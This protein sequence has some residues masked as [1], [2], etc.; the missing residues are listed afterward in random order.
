MPLLK[1]KR[2]PPVDTPTYDSTKKESKESAKPIWQ[3]EATGKS[4]LTYMEALKSEKE[5]KDRTGNKLSLELQKRVLLHIQFQTLRLDA[6][7]D[8][9]YKYFVNRYIPGELVQC[10]WDD[11]IA[12][13]GK[14]L[15]VTG[16]EGDQYKVQLVDEESL[17]IE[18]M[19]KV[20]PK[21]KIK[22]DR[23]A[24]SK[25]FLKKFIKEH[26]IKDTYI[27][28]PWNIKPETAEKFNIDTTLPEH[29][30][31]ARNTAYAKSRKKRTAMDAALNDT[32]D[33][34]KPS[35][36]DPRKLEQALRYPI[37]DLN[38]PTYRRDPSGFGKIID[39]TPGTEEA[40]NTVPN[41][42]GNMPLHPKSTHNTTV[43]EDCYGSFLMIWS[44]LSVF[45]HPL[46]LSPFTLDDFESALQYKQS[47]ILMRECNVAL[48]NAI[49]KQR[50]RLKKESQGNGSTAVAA[51]MSLYGSGYEASRSTSSSAY[52][53][54]LRRFASEDT[55]D[56]NHIWR[57]R[58]PIKHRDT[59]PDRGCGS[60]E[61]EAISRDW[62][63]GTVDTEE[64][65]EGWEDILIGFLNQLAPLE[66]LEDIDRIL[67]SIVLFPECTLEDRE[68]AY[69]S[70]NLR[71]KVKIFE[72]LISV[73]NESYIIKSY[74]D[75][76]QE[77]M[78]ELRKQK[79]EL[80][81]ER[82]RIN[83]E[84]R[85]LEDKQNEENN[86]IK[87]EQDEI[88][89]SDNDSV[90]SDNEDSALLRAQRQ[91]EH[92]TRHESRQEAMRR[93]QAER[94]ER[95]AKRVKLHH[96]QREEARARN[97][98]QKTR[99]ETR[100]RLDDEERMLHKKEE[101]VEREL[102]KY[103][104]HRIKPLGRD[105]FYNRYYY[106]DDVG[107]T[108]LHGSGRLF[109]QCPSDTDLI[110]IQ[111]RD[112][113][114]SLDTKVNAPC[115]RGGGTNF[116]SQLL[117]GQGFEK[118]SE[119]MEQRLKILNGEQVENPVQSWWHVYDNPEQLDELLLWLNPKGIREYRL[120]RELE[121]YHQNL[122]AGMKKRL[123]DQANTSKN[124]VFRRATR[125]KSTTT[126][127]PGSWLAY[128]NKLA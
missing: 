99:N 105:K 73:A 112:H 49:I 78:T 76:C 61:I 71:D 8:D 82:K 50:D 3:C 62:D 9:T 34:K 64:E 106:L 45:A 1:R 23:F 81:R 118:E 55:I 126:F 17:G 24:F 115:G 125:N 65:R 96:L 36:V 90:T 108:L 109:V 117:K 122:V 104:T 25:N 91:Q 119:Y 83:A 19:I 127:A 30:Y 42:T 29:L 110:I 53:E 66:M 21:D 102:R 88:S 59:N 111:E 11:N 100:K 26:A 5:E 12:Y 10:T 77:Q 47:S 120:K 95:E 84:R 4:G 38:I 40:N 63:H 114:E 79:I 103:N 87:E 93:R 123:T 14:V 41:P 92:L 54:T 46:K 94:E 13:H 86:Q 52:Q 57:F 69:A 7:V 72:L 32:S 20:L 124:E 98:E 101:Q 113:I 56:E 80:S 74:M 43:P 107:G 6:L 35:T 18:D 22:R 116:V 48:L 33:S 128:T 28:A 60:P 16:D 89:D 85:E 39:M 2:V 70:L 51:A 75:E 31:E 37:E 15:E 44:F 97:L 121:K 68:N 58:P 67:A 27:G